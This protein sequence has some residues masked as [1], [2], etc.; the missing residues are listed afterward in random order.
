MRQLLGWQRPWITEQD[1]FS[2]MQKQFLWGSDWKG[3]WKCHF[4][5]QFGP[6]FDSSW[7]VMIVVT[8]E[9]KSCRKDFQPLNEH[10]MGWDTY[11]GIFLVPCWVFPNILVVLDML[12]EE[13]SICPATLDSV[14]IV[15]EALRVRQESTSWRFHGQEDH[16][17]E[18]VLYVQ[19]DSTALLFLRSSNPPEQRRCG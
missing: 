1:T 13:W 16:A 15:S 17:D 9:K 5:H 10:C 11:R 6:F 12:L 2:R 8:A 18:V 4:S 19:E 14:G 7:E 3:R